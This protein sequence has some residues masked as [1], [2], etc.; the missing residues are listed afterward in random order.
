MTNQIQC[1]QCRL[2]KTCACH[3]EPSTFASARLKSGARSALCKLCF[4][5]RQ[6]KTETQINEELRELAFELKIE[7]PKSH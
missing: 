5:R 3:F 1:R 2:Q 4:A 7:Q 6:N